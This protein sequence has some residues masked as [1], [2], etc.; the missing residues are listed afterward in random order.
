MSDSVV[1]KLTFV[2]A[3]VLWVPACEFDF[4]KRP[5]TGWLQHVASREIGRAI[6]KRKDFDYNEEAL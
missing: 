4:P 2:A 1:E 3:T 6:L 5:A